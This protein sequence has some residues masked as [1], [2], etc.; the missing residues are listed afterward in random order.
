MWMYGPWN[1][2]PWFPWMWIFPLIVLVVLFLVFRGRGA[3]MCGHGTHKTEETAR[4]VLDR[5][6]ALGEIDREEYMRMK[7][8]IE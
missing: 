1:G 3:F 8:D 5:R 6:Y 7:K 2:F 4:E